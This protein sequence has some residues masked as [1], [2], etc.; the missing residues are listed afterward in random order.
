MTT[1]WLTLDMAINLMAVCFAV[2]M[3]A[4]VVDACDGGGK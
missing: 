1:D 4:M 2:G 3:L